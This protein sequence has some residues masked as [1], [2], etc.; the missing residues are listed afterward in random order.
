[1]T[2]RVKTTDSLHMVETT[3]R[4][5]TTVTVQN[6]GKGKTTAK[7]ETT[8]DGNNTTV[9]TTEGGNDR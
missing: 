7:V 8:K 4:L 2:Q 5:E 9:A 3:G 6:T 1:M